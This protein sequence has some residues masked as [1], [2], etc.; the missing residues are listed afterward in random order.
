MS[1]ADGIF[2]CILLQA[3]LS[4]NNIFRVIIAF[5]PMFRNRPCYGYSAIVLLNDFFFHFLCL[6][7][8][9]GMVSVLEFLVLEMLKSQDNDA[10]NKVNRRK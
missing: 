10:G 3:L 8:D 6:E 5:F 2:R 1:Y 4:F 9:A 7:T